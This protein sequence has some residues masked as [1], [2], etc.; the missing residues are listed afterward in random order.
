MADIKYLDKTGLGTV[1]SI[2]D[3]LFAP[4]SHNHNTLYY[5]KTESDNLLAGKSNTGHDHNN[6]Y[7][8]ISHGVHWN[9]FS[10]RDL[11]S[12]TWGTLT[13]SNG[14]TINVDIDKLSDLRK[15]YFNFKNDPEKKHI[16]VIAQDVQKIY[17]EIVNENTDGMLTVD[18]SKLSVIALDA[19]D[20]LNQKNKELEDRLNKIENL[21]KD[22]GIL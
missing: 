14:D 3:G 5:T 20:Q 16:G 1:K 4:K 19:V 7:A 9:N 2:L 21:L 11:N 13:T 12:A 18:Y 22:K 10:N 8:T 15:V 17:P 6:V